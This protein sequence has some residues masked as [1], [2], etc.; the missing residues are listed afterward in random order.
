MW[1][2]SVGNVRS[3]I[4]EAC[5]MLKERKFEREFVIDVVLNPEWREEG[6]GDIWYAFRRVGERVVRV[7]VR[8]EEKPYIIVTVYFDRRLRRRYWK[9]EK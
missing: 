7:V 3:Q 5:G 1:D 4:Y 2:R 9:G 6:E 8:G